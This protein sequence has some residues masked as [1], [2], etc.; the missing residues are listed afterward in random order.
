MAALGSWRNRLLRRR[1]RAEVPAKDVGTT[2]EHVST[3]HESVDEERLHALLKEDPNDEVRF[4]EMANVVRR[5]AA[6]GHAGGDPERAQADAVWA[7][8]EEL[9]HDSRSWYP[10]VELARLSLAD[11]REAALRR[12][13]VAAERDPSG[14][15]LTHGLVLLREAGDDDGALSLGMGHWRPTEHPLGAGREMVSAAVDAHRLAEAR[16]H[17]DALG[18]HPDATG[19]AAMRRDLE[20]AITAA[21]RARRP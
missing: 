3:V 12:L 14:T 20:R 4:A 11:D 1:D 19:V 6:E 5:R 8:A 7:L 10:L 16:R 2:S 15:A 21:E 18:A 17:L 13:G 9:A